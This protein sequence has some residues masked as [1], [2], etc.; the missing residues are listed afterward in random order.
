MKGSFLYGCTQIKKNSMITLILNLKARV[1]YFYQIFILHQMIALQKVWKMFL[2]HLK[3]SFSSQDIQIFVFRSS[4]LILP[5]SHCFRDW[6]KVNLKVYDI[7][8]SRNKKLITHFVWYLWK[9]KRYDIETLF[10][11]RVLNEEHFY[12]EIMHKMCTKS[13][14]KTPF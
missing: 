1:C 9:E 11:D 12:G 3:S 6:S 8:N 4:P 10:I 2:F 5:V 14:Y 13:Y 7:I